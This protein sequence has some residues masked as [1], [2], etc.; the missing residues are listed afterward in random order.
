MRV[1]I[2][3]DKPFRVFILPV[4]SDKILKIPP[5]E[6][7]KEAIDTIQSA[8]RDGNTEGTVELDNGVTLQWKDWDDFENDMRMKELVEALRLCHGIPITPDYHKCLE[9][10]YTLV[11]SIE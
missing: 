2:L 11:E 10:L 8:M 3:R 9:E 5:G 1:Y 4:R 7:H 6:I